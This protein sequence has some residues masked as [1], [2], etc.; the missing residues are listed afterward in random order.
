[1]FDETNVARL[2]FF[3]KVPLCTSR[4]QMGCV[5]TYDAFAMGYE[6]D[7]G[8]LLKF[9]AAALQAPCTN[10]GSLDGGIARYGGSTFAVTSPA[11]QL[12]VSSGLAIYPDLFTGQCAMGPSGWSVLDVAFAPLAGDVRIDPVLADSPSASPGPPYFL[13]V[14]GFDVAFPTRELLDAVGTRAS[15]L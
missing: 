13:G 1:V 6:P 7:G 2:T 4:T 12:P 10:P 8:P 15:A 3:Q 11:L 9:D 5:I 14:H